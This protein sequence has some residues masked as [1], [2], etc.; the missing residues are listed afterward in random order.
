MITVKKVPLMLIKRHEDYNNYK[1]LLFGNEHLLKDPEILTV[2]ALNILFEV[3]PIVVVKKGRNCF[4]IAGRRTYTLAA[5]KL[6]MDALVPVHIINRPTKQLLDQF[7]CTDILIS[8]L[9]IGVNKNVIGKIYKAIKFNAPDSIETLTVVNNQKELCSALNC[10]RAT[11][12][13][14]QRSKENPYES[15]RT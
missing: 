1:K 13:P 3:Q 11:L 15:E 9:L 7:I 4:Y 5:Q 12:F 14:K 2:A 6:K 10:A 8:N